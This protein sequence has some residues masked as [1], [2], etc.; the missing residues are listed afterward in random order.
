MAFNVSSNKKK[1]FKGGMA[2]SSP[3][4]TTT[5][6]SYVKIT[7]TWNNM[8]VDNDDFTVDGVGRITCNKSGCYHF[9]GDSNLTASSAGKI[10]YALYKNGLLIPGAETPTDVVSA[11]KIGAIGINS[12]IEL[13]E[14]DYLEVWVKSDSANSVTSET[15]LITFMGD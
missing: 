13:V 6:P 5:S 7:G 2:L 1:S 8:L 12:F 10:Y 3:K 4:T 11:S 9:V 14:T 15:L